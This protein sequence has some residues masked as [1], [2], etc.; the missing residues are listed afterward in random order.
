MRR[1]E[2]SIG[3]E[4]LI[5]MLNQVPVWNDELSPGKRE[6]ELIS[7]GQ[8]NEVLGG[9]S[10]HK[11]PRLPRI[12]S[13]SEVGRISIDSV[14][15][16]TGSGEWRLSGSADAQSRCPSTLPVS[17]KLL[18]C[19]TSHVNSPRH[20]PNYEAAPAHEPHSPFGMLALAGDIEL[21]PLLPALPTGGGDI[22][23]MQLP[24]SSAE[25]SAAAQ[26]L[27]DAC[28]ESGTFA[29]MYDRVPQRPPQGFPQQ[30]QQ[31][32]QLQHRQRQQQYEPQVDNAESFLLNH[33]RWQEQ[34]RE[35]LRNADGYTRS[36]L[37]AATM[38]HPCGT[39]EVLAALSPRQVQALH[40]PC[41]ELVQSLLRRT[42][43][44][45][46]IAIPSLAQIPMAY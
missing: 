2:S 9:S 26:Q 14:L 32:E 11:R 34:L 22:P 27:L 28:A 31:Q 15:P 16:L 36:L 37:S 41:R 19:P 12:P 39:V 43:A 29:P 40:S 23:G 4:G 17:M 30:Q 38:H 42:I 13:A 3:A 46:A 8:A 35:A 44:Q 45:A 7:D 25:A 10:Q 24:E 21:S 20:E 33:A 18:S 5:E 6:F 1:A